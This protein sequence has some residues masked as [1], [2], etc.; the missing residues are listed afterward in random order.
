MLPLPE[1][2]L[3]PEAP[4]PLPPDWEPVP[5]LPL[6]PLVPPMLPLLE[7]PEL[8]MLPLEPVLSLLLCF[9]ECFLVDLCGVVVWVLWSCELAL[10]PPVEEPLLVCA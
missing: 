1:V 6:V 10:V 3:E 2:P 9:L 7:L 5:M 4:L 8:S